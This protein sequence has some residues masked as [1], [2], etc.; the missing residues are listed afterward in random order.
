MHKLAVVLVLL[1]VVTRGFGQESSTT[2]TAEPYNTKIEHLL[3][4]AEHLEAAGLFEDACKVR[5]QAANVP[6]WEAEIDRRRALGIPTPQVL[7]KIRVLELSQTKLQK[8][9]FSLEYVFSVNDVSLTDAKTPTYAPHVVTKSDAVCS[10]VLASPDALL[11]VLDALQKDHLAKVM[12][13][14]T[15][16]TVNN[17]PVSFHAGGESR[18]A[19]P[20]G[21]GKVSVEERPYGTMVDFIP[22][23]SD[24]QTIQLTCRIEVSQLDTTHGVAVAGEIVPALRMVRVNTATRCRS[25]QTVVLRGLRQQR[26][27]SSAPVASGTSAGAAPKANDKPKVDAGVEEIETLV[28]LT[29]E[30]VAPTSM[31]CPF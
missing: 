20:Q 2:A 1:G 31:G 10:S 23:V 14:P 13:E 28:L 16:V 30:I 17:R 15:L 27:I 7:L 26:S 5:R 3:K 4:A 18:V 29:P 12:A 25:G 6:A 24:D 22:V 9:G 11:K 19:V 8:L 21:N